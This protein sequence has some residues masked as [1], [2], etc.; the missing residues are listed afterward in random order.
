ERTAGAIDTATRTLLTQ[1]LLPNLDGDL[2]AGMYVKVRFA[3]AGGRPLLVPANTLVIN[4]QGIRVAS[5]G[6]DKTLHYQVVQLGRDYG[7]EV[8]VIQGL[9]GSERLVLN[10]TE[11]LV[12]GV[13]VDA[14]LAAPVVK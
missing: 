3:E 8:E 10:P 2:Y 11:N 7:K 9:Q 1:V 5:V 4:T 13:K 12:E 14:T 6:P